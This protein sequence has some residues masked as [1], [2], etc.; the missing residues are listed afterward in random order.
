MIFLKKSLHLFN[1]FIINIFF[2][3]ILICLAR[4][5][6]EAD[7]TKIVA[8]D[9]ALNFTF[10]TPWNQDRNFFHGKPCNEFDTYQKTGGKIKWIFGMLPAL[11]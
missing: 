4:Q 6:K 8:D 3:I 11:W 10:N 5:A 1:I 2:L 7:M 9:K